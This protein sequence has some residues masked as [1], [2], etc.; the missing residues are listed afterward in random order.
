MTDDAPDNATPLSDRI[1]VVT[2]RVEEATPLSDLLRNLG[3]EVLVVPAIRHQATG[4]ETAEVAAVFTPEHFTHAAFTSRVAVRFF[5]ALLEQRSQA[6]KDALLRRWRARRFAAVG[7]RTARALEDGGLASESEVLVPPDG[8]GAA[9]LGR[10][11]L[12]AGA[13]TPESRILVP[14]SRLARPELG[15]ILREGGVAVELAPLYDTLPERREKAGPFLQLLEHGRLPDAITFFSPS[16]V[17]GFLEITAGAGGRALRDPAL[18]I[19]SV[20]PTTSQEVVAQGLRV[21]GEAHSPSPA[22]V[23]EA[24]RAALG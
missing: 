13:L 22:A 4:A 3:A 8:E 20:G 18:R 17:R 23:V 5:L 2:R 16:A 19:I 9:A 7:R 10:A 12:S 14:G 1:V 21:A 6:E 15:E 24:V 11:L